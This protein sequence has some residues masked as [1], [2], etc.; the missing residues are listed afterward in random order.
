M[1]DMMAMMGGKIGDWI[2][3]V[4]DRGRDDYWRD[5]NEG[6]QEHMANQSYGRQKEFAQMGIQWRTADAIAAGVHPL[7]AISGGGAAY[8]SP[9]VSISGG[10]SHSP[11]GGSSQLYETSQERELRMEQMNALKA[12]SSRDAA[13]AGYY[14][15]LEAKERQAINGGPRTL[16]GDPPSGQGDVVMPSYE[17][18]DPGNVGAVKLSGDPQVSH[19]PGDQ[20]MSAGER[21]AFWKEYQVTPDGLRVALPWTQEGPGEALEN[22]S[23]WMWPSIVAMNKA[24]YGDDW[25]GQFIAQV[26]LGKRPEYRHATEQMRNW[27]SPKVKEFLSKSGRERG[28]NWRRPNRET[29]YGWNVR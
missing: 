20:S 27:N 26:V 2:S 7:Y 15:A 16:L 23:W 22:V 25:L 6:W 9:G 18:T 19:A 24:R 29:S 14:S 4:V 12:A 13:Q 21:S 1:S 28:V 3:G 11:V 10:V 5:R 8:N 17:V